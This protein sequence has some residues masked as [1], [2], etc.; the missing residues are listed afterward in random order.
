M[1]LQIYRQH[2]IKQS[3]FHMTLLFNASSRYNALPPPPITRPLLV[4]LSIAEKS[5]ETQ[6]L[7]FRHVTMTSPFLLILTT[8]KVLDAL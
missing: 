7:Y 5:I 3:H 8:G 6:Y 4:R 2:F 1:Q